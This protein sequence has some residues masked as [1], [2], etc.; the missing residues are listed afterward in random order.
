MQNEDGGW[1][2]LPTM[3]SDAYATG[4]R[5]TVILNCL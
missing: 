2:Q 1:S 5:V 4:Q 3:K